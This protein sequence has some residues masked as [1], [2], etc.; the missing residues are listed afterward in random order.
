MKKTSL[1]KLSESQCTL[2]EP[3]CNIFFTLSCISLF[4]LFLMG[5]KPNNIP[6]QHQVMVFFS[7]RSPSGSLLKSTATPAED[8]ISEIILFAINDKDEIVETFPLSSS[9]GRLT[10]SRKITSLYAIANPGDIV[11]ATYTTGLQLRNLTANFSAKPASPF[12]MSGTAEIPYASATV[13]IRLVRAVAKININ[14]VDTGFEI[15]SVTVNNTPAKG[16]VFSKTPFSVP[17][18]DRVTY[19]YSAGDLAI[20]PSIYVA[21]NSPNQTEFVVTGKY[22]G[23]QIDPYTFKLTKGNNMYIEIKRNTCYQ[24]DIKF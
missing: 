13:N 3:Q 2:S 7:T 9:G 4:M 5:C 19:S 6:E 8:Q 12:L 15:E 24:V 10:L 20:N 22:Q 21:E 1:Q 17:T 11:W 16:Y 23:R 18:S 14:V